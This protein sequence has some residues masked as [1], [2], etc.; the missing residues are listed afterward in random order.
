MD[1]SKTLHNVYKMTKEI[2]STTFVNADT[3]SLKKQL[4]EKENKERPMNVPITLEDFDKVAPAV[5]ISFV[6]GGKPSELHNLLDGNLPILEFERNMTLVDQMINSYIK[7]NPSCNVDLIKRCKF[8]YSSEYIYNCKSDLIRTRID[9][10][11]NK[12][13]ND[14][15][16]NFLNIYELDNLISKDVNK[17]FGNYYI[18]DLWKCHLSLLG[19]DYYQRIFYDDKEYSQQKAKEIFYLIKDI[20]MI[21]S[22]YKFHN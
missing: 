4:I 1:I 11:K 16:L 9:F 15:T 20:L 21:R 12:L 22:M 5:I 7:S 6:F 8:V 19:S 13:G 3:N 2:L 17:R 10:T 18:K 14:Y